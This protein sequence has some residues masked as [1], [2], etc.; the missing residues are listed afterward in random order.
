MKNRTLAALMIL[1]S[2]SLLLAAC[3]PASATPTP[4]PIA[5]V[6]ADDIV[7]AEGRVEPVRFTQLALNAAWSWMFFG[8][9]SPNHTVLS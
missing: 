3:S 7:V 4:E 8:A 5:T 6:K 1:V 9:H 2:L